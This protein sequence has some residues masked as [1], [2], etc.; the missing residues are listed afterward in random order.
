LETVG[1][2]VRFRVSH[3]LPPVFILPVE[4]AEG[5]AGAVVGGLRFQGAEAGPD[6]RPEHPL[7]RH[8]VQ[9]QSRFLR[10]VIDPKQS[11]QAEI[12]QSLAVDRDPPSLPSRGQSDGKDEPVCLRLTGAS[13]LR[14]P[15]NPGSPADANC[16]RVLTGATDTL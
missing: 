14:A 11:A 8:V 7:R 10:R 6:A 15:G 12:C 4:R 2:R 3:L 16:H 9:A 1:I 13:H 5:G